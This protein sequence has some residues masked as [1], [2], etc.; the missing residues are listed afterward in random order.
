MLFKL[1]ATNS[2][3]ELSRDVLKVVFYL[4]ERQEGEYF[5]SFVCFERIETGSLI[6]IPG[7]TFKTRLDENTPYNQLLAMA[8]R[9][10][11]ILAEHSDWQ[12]NTDKLKDLQTALELL[13]W[14][15][16]RHF[17]QECVVLG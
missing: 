11:D 14:A 3:L 5:H 7:T 9:V 12:T 17:K 16:N 1:A 13:S 10:L 2:A 8:L 4:G 6:M 15:D